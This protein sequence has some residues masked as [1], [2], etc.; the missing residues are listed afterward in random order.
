M[1]NRRKIFAALLIFVFVFLGGV[2]GFKTLGG[3]NWSWTDSL[4]MTVI[5]VSTVG[6]GEVVDMASNP[7]ARLFASV[8]I[9]LCLGTIA[10]AISSITAFVVEGELKNILWRKKMD[11]E[12]SKLTDHYIICGSDSTAQTIISELLLTRKRF[13]VVEPSTEKLDKL[14]SL[15][16]FSFV[17][18]DPTED[19]TLITAGIMRAKGVLLSLATDEENLFVTLTAKDL[20]PHIRVITKGIDIKSHRKMEK[21][22]AD[23]VISPSF[24]GGMRMV[25]EMIRPAVV[26]FLDMML[27]DREEVLRFEEVAVRNMPHLIGK[28]VSDFISENKTGALLVALK[29]TQTG[30]Y[31]FN[32]KAEWKLQED[33]IL[34]LMGSPEMIASLENAESP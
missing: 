25:S 6:Y 5:T 12:I 30:K 7:G 20:N 24:I 15:G 29:N 23:V 3:E 33:D 22:G 1:G 4:Y 19:Q 32:P 34:L 18:G 11:K 31:S 14:K 9:I 10:F 21:A 16:E 27:R 13:V 26:S 28:M 8:F 17:S 2:V